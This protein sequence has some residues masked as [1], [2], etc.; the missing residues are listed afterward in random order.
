MTP[1]SAEP[2]LCVDV[3]ST[4]TK[5][6]LVD[7]AGRGG[8]PVLAAASAPTVLPPHG[9]V[10]DGVSA[11]RAAVAASAGVPARTLRGER[12]LVCSSAGGGLRLAVV[13]Y[14][15]LVSAEAGHRVAL[16]AGGTVVHVHAGPLATAGVDA[17]R[18]ALP[19]VVLLVGGTDGGN[20]EVLLH[21]ARRLG[22]A[23]VPVPVV[24][25]GNADAA[26][27][28]EGELTRRG[29]HVVVAD[30]VLPRIG[31]LEPRP[32]RAAIRRMFL[33][34]V[35]G[36]KGLSRKALDG[37]RFARLVGAPTPD[38]VLAGVEVLAEAVGRDVLVVDVGGATTDVYSVITPLGEDA[39]LRRDVVGR[40][41]HARTVEGDLGMRWSA[42][43]VVAAARTERL[44]EDP[45]PLAAH[46]RRMVAD[47][48][49]LPAT[50]SERELD[51]ALAAAA[52]RV[53]VRRHGRPAAP[54]AAPRPLREVAWVIGSGGVLRHGDEAL[55]RAVLGPLT[56]D[57][58]G[59][60][61]VPE[62]A[63]TAVDER[64]VLFAA[65]L[66]APT[67]PDAAL[68]LARTVVAPVGQPVK[69]SAEMIL[70]A[71]SLPLGAV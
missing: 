14:E 39:E 40:L 19:D 47:V 3:G 50:A 10:L 71:S 57:H 66:L 36:G 70:T 4:Y 51:G 27:E 48:S 46:A 30:N 12:L 16:S 28:A 6:L 31:D 59:G 24:L 23:R 15:Q 5:A 49:A 20:A 54:G 1:A 34:H 32:A 41:W 64:Y 18:A 35:I 38:A 67:R 26:A 11:V 60:W 22:A 58:G 52:A 37:V 69:G 45:A 21:N 2:V 55:R 17:L 7:V 61:A 68:A 29:R 53:A 43:G 8:D 56:A 25:A 44:L 65:G 63:R 9:D 62:H 13:G 42:Q 33:E